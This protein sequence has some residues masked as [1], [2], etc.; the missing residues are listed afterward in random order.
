MA[1]TAHN[2]PIIETT[3]DTN[4][5]K[6]PKFKKSDF[7]KAIDAQGYNVYVEKA[8]RCP[9]AVVGS[10][11]QAECQNCGGSGWIF[12]NKVSTKAILH[13]INRTTK[14]K[15]WTEQ[16][17]GT[18]SVTVKDTVRLAFMDKITILDV[19]SIYTQR[20][21]IKKKGTDIFGYLFYIA[22]EIEH[23]F[24]YKNNTTALIPLVETTDWVL[25]ENI[26]TF[27]STV[28]QYL[29][30]ENEARVVVRYKHRP[31][32][33]IVDINREVVKY[34]TS[35]KDLDCEPIVGTKPKEE[36]P[37]HGIAKKA[38]YL[39]DYKNL[40]GES[41]FDNTDQPAE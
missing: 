20:V 7:D 38:H 41:L 28:E 3:P 35:D 25:D 27:T 8:L 5:G 10:G 2:K 17:R 36:L 12:I 40:S 9:C 26:L 13:S 31:S 39:L 11:S 29:N 23:M 6:Q 16:D 1:K 34:T 15:D 4:D 18:M 37:I 30:S 21:T 32:Y 33:N 22:T 19:D 24:L 14:Y